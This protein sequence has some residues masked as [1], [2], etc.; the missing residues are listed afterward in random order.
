MT[1]NVKDFGALGNGVAN[2]TAAIQA[3]I[4]S[5]AAKGGGT[6]FFPEGTYNVNTLNLNVRG[7]KLQGSGWLGTRITGMVQ[8]TKVINITADFCGIDSLQVS[9][10]GHTPDGIGSIGVYSNANNCT[11][12]NFRIYNTAVGI[13]LDKS[14]IA[15]MNDFYIETFS[16]AGIFMDHWIDVYA[17]NFVIQASVGSQFGKLACIYVTN[18]CDALLMS[19]ADI[20]SG[21][22]A[23]QCEGAS[24]GMNYS[25]FT[26]ICFDSSLQETVRLDRSRMNKFTNCWFSGGRAGAGFEG[27]TIANS[28]DTR[29]VNCDFANNGGHGATV[30]DTNVN[31][32]FTDCVFD[33]NSYT[34]GPGYYHG[35]SIWPNAKTFFVTGCTFKNGSFAGQQGFGLLVNAGASDKY[36]LRDNLF[37]GNTI[38]GL[39]DGGTGTTKVVTGNM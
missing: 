5:L 36:I 26:N 9:F 12:T 30:K 15:I 17:T 35:L 8:G 11:F 2:D 28:Q 10:Y 20:L 29:F 22:H 38:V 25:A 39:S 27:M 32:R 7:V 19:N 21:R 23:L 1:V 14:T 33:S 6:V 16:Q 24:V 37:I 18:G 34:G 31:T 13:Y 3:A 4:N